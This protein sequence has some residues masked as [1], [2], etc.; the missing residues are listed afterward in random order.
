[1]QNNPPNH[2]QQN[3]EPY[4][5]PGLPE[6]NYDQSYIQ[7]QL[8]QQMAVSRG[9]N[10]NVLEI[11]QESA[12]RLGNH[13]G[14]VFLGWLVYI[15]SFTLFWIVLFYLIQLFLAAVL[16]SVFLSVAVS[17]FTFALIMKL[18]FLFIFIF[19]A[20]ITCSMIFYFGFLSYISD[21]I[22]FDTANYSNIFTGFQKM[23]QIAG[24]VAL[25][26]TP[27]IIFAVIT[28]IPF[29]FLSGFSKL[30]N[31]APQPV[32]SINNQATDFDPIPYNPDDPAQN[33]Y[34]GNP[35]FQQSNAKSG[36]NNPIITAASVFYSIIVLIAF[37]LYVSKL[38]LVPN[39]LIAQDMKLGEAVKES[40]NKVKGSTFLHI[41]LLLI[42]FGVLAYLINIVSVRY[43]APAMMSSL[44]KWSL[45]RYS[46]V[47]ALLVQVVFV[48]FIG[49]IAHVYNTLYPQLVRTDPFAIASKY[50]R[51]TQR[52]YSNQPQQQASQQNQQPYQPIP[53][54][55]TPQSQT[56]N[57]AAYN[58][59]D[60]PI[61]HNT[62]TY[63]PKPIKTSVHM[64]DEIKTEQE[65]DLPDKHQTEKSLEANLQ[66]S[67]Q[68]DEQ[69]QAEDKVEKKTEIN[70]K[71]TDKKEV[72]SG[73]V[74]KPIQ[75]VSH[76]RDSEKPSQSVHPDESQQFKPSWIHTEESPLQQT[77]HI[78]KFVDKQFE[79][80]AY[81]MGKIVPVDALRMMKDP[82]IRFIEVQF[83]DMNHAMTILK[84]LPIFSIDD[85]SKE[86]CIEKPLS[87]SFSMPKIP[88]NPVKL[89]FGGKE[90][91]ELDLW[92]SKEVIIENLAKIVRINHAKTE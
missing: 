8:N 29:G 9:I 73:Y 36:I 57:P 40:W 53:Q 19:I 20:I 38:I 45:I 4:N 91:T 48:Y 85:D 90:M 16:T 11:M 74:K 58:P 7:Q 88:T 13:F 54:Q 67:Q 28:A 41:F 92:K 42:I 72:K 22:E 83:Q 55:S 3:Q 65:A 26:V 14:N 21:L 39:L 24:L 71:D 17:G 30:G 25:V 1:M 5:R 86:I 56:F 52:K 15:F 12:K 66:V 32:S 77:S 76:P 84:L 79:K 78:T 81:P 44:T 69:L 82:E 75:Y 46:I 51:K 43:I 27:T 80:D 62:E 63:V 10:I 35:N 59:Y 34:Q 33:P 70:T 68:E 64:H 89:F 37:L 18:I 50:G 60:P 61:E 2:P 47:N 87:F 6:Q 31:T 49:C 23:F